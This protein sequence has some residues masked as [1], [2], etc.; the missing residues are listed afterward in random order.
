MQPAIARSYLFV[1]GNRPER[2]A[3]AV[4]AGADEVIVDLEDAVPPAEKAEA[5]R[6]AAN[7]LSKEKPTLLRINA[8]TTDWFRDDLEI[9]SLPGVTGVVISKAEREED[10]AAVR[11]KASPS[12]RILPLVETARGFWNALKL[13]QAP[14]VQRLIFGSLDL[15]LD[16][17]MNTEDEA[18]LSFR[19]QMVLLS[20]LAGI[21]APVD[22][23]HTAIDDFERLRAETLRSR[24][25]GFGG[26]LV[27]HPKQIAVVHECFQ[28]S[29]EEV[30]WA[31]RVLEAASLSQG[32]A[33][34]MGGELVDRPIIARA[35]SILREAGA[36]SSPP[37]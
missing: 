21:Q 28:P 13:A 31:K 7:W 17:G 15:Q 25:L 36:R 2:F 20:R 8:V 14:S 35:E 4:A 23:I 1:P 16:L 30:A 10:L 19:L 3:K 26:K 37:H 6:A 18:L 27:I 22:G 33:V 34:A 11:D 32:S 5:R 12:A 29:A 9:C 24:R